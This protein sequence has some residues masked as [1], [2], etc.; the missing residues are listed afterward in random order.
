MK[1][2]FV[3]DRA[4][5]KLPPVRLSICFDVACSDRFG[6]SPIPICWHRF[7]YTNSYHLS[8]VVVSFLA[9]LRIKYAAGQFDC[10]SSSIFRKSWALEWTDGR[11]S[12]AARGARGGWGVAASGTCSQRCLYALALWEKVPRFQK[13]TRAKSQKFP[14]VG[15]ASF[16]WGTLLAMGA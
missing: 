3:I 6:I 12:C 1:G 11:I 8:I 15:H 5:L 4:S 2:V 9:L 7:F 10:R 14:S 13:S 16:Q